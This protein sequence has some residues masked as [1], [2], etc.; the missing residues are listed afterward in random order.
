MSGCATFFI[1][2]IENPELNA[3]IDVMIA[4]APAVSLAHSKTSI[5]YR[6]PFVNQIVVCI[7]FIPLDDIIHHICQKIKDF[8]ETKKI[9]L[10]ISFLLL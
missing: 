5:R 2:M 9:S 7:L 8:S 4:L 3:K 10:T 6:A 1:G